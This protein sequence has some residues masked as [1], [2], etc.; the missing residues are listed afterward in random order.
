M[1]LCSR[2]VVVSRRRVI[3]GDSV[4]SIAASEGFVDWRAIWDHPEN[5]ELRALRAS[6]HILA[7]GD[8]VFV[9]ERVTHQQS[10]AT[11]QRHRF[12]VRVPT[13]A[14][15]MTLKDR[16]GRALANR[17]FELDAGGVTRSGTTD[18]DGR[19]EVSVPATAS[20]GELR[21]LGANGPELTMPLAIDHLDPV[22]QPSGVRQR[23]RHLG[24]LPQQ[25]PDPRAIEAALRDF[26]RAHRLPESGTADDATC[27]TLREKHKC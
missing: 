18:G 22:E 19:F 25:D 3:Q 17:R 27:A 5:T 9:P 23:L 8:V 24:F 14:I 12:V 16:R 13:I 10:V 2:V 11:G 21:L 6:P 4:P 1:V 15:K 20:S 7:E 26:Q